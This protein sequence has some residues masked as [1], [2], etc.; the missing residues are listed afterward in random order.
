MNS[1]KIIK[2]I[3]DNKY[4]I[5]AIIAILFLVHMF[6]KKEA[7]TR[8]NAMSQQR[9]LDFLMNK[10]TNFTD[11][12]KNYIIGFLKKNLYFNGSV[13]KQLNALDKKLSLQNLK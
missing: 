6:M 1:T 3:K 9:Y 4:T 10:K 8:R 7:F 12:E 2:T 13:D 5:I 11:I